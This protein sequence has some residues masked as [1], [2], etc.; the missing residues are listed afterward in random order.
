MSKVTVKFTVC[1]TL[2][3]S[4]ALCKCIR[5]S[6]GLNFPATVVF[7]F[8]VVPFRSLFYSPSFSVIVLPCCSFSAQF[9]PKHFIAALHARRAE[10]S[11]SCNLSEASWPLGERGKGGALARRPNGGGNGTTTIIIT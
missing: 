2:P 7:V 9:G 8:I 6:T 4:W 11:F 5:K 3:P 1:F 10:F